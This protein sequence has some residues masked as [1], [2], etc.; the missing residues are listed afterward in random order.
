MRYVP[1]R[2]CENAISSSIPTYCNV[3]R[4]FIIVPT[5]TTY[6]LPLLFFSSV[7]LRPKRRVFST[8]P[9]KSHIFWSKRR[10]GVACEM[11]PVPTCT[12]VVVSGIWKLGFPAEHRI[13]WVDARRCTDCEFDS[14]DRRKRANRIKTRSVVKR[15]DRLE[16]YDTGLSPFLWIVRR[17]DRIRLLNKILILIFDIV[18]YLK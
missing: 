9:F 4:I 12:L 7:A 10:N 18:Q 5:Y 11:C 3:S 14:F 16:I 1:P 2:T 13:Q 8:I 6:Q 17:R 15:M